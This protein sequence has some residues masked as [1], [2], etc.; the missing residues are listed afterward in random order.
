M[1]REHNKLNDRKIRSFKEP[2]RYSDGGNLYLVVSDAGSKSWSFMFTR[3]GE[4]RELGLGGYPDLSLAE[5]RQKAIEY[6]KLLSQGLDPYEQKRAEARERERQARLKRTFEWCAREYIRH[7]QVE[8]KNPKHIAQWSSTL[9]RYAFPVIGSLD[10]SEI[11]I[12]H[13]T[14]ILDPI[15]AEKV[16]TASRLRGRIENILDWAKVRGHRDGENPAAW[17]GNLSMVYS[18]KSAIRKVQHHPALPYVD[19]ADFVA[20][21]RD[22]ESVSAKALEFLILSAGRTGEVICAD[23]AEINRDA[24]LWTIPASRMKSGVQHVVPLSKRALQIIEEMGRQGSSPFVFPGAN[25]QLP[26]SNMAFLQLLKRMGRTDIT[27]HG[28]RSSF[29][30]WA[31]DLTEYSNQVIEKAIAHTVGGVEAAY[32]RGDL[33]EKRRRLM[34]DWADYVEGERS[35]IKVRKAS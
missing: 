4:R 2:K 29:R 26:M 22:R 33:L 8:W 16:E 32:R 30:D 7:R 12:N 1:A 28:F 11:R 34:D 31:A 6:R 35:V 18:P 13:I 5:A 27:V 3:L 21:L 20:D 10:V 14:D 25:R 19:I 17:R 24:A 9:E 23:C 15:W